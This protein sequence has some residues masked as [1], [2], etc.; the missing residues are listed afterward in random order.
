MTGERRIC[1]RCGS[2]FYIPACRVAKGE[3]EFC[4]LICHNINQGRGKT[5]HVCKTCGETFRWSPSRTAS[6]NYNPTYCSPP[7]RDADPSRRERLVEMNAMQQLGRTTKI[8]ANGYALLDSLGIDYLRQET[9]AGKFTPDATI[10]SARL[11]VQ[12]DGDYWHDRKGTSTEARI[13]RRVRLDQSQDAYIRACGWDVLRLWETDL[14][15][16]PA[17]CA[18]LLRQ[19]LHLPARAQ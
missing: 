15:D 2:P 7:C 13:R 16:D 9:F 10:P 18:D 11:I 1:R 3:G 6:G 4:S 17:G 12:F 5:E 19:R 8:E 14:R